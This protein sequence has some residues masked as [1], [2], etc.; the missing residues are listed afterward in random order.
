MVWAGPCS[1]WIRILDIF[2]SMDIDIF[3]P[4]HGPL[5]TKDDVRDARD[6]LIFIMEAGHKAYA[7][8]IRDP[9]EAAYQIVVPEKWKH[10]GEQERVV[11]NMCTFWKEVDPGYKTPEFF[12]LMCIAGEYHRHINKVRYQNGHVRSLI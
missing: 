3:V 11:M 7:A 9:V 10:Y 2:I 5:G 12:E 8:G 4:G 6:I 1:S